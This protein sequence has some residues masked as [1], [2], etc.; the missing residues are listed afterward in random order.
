VKRLSALAAL[1]VC[2]LSGPLAADDIS[3]P[4]Y[5]GGPLSVEA[6]WEFLISPSNLPPPQ[7]WT[8]ILPDT[9]SSVGGSGGETLY[10]GFATH[11]DAVSA[12][13]W[14]WVIGD[15]DG[16]LTPVFTTGA[17]IAF[18]VQNWVDV[19][20]EKLL[21][22]QVTYSGAVSPTITN[23]LAWD[24]VANNPPIGVPAPSMLLGHVNVDPN[25]FYEDWSIMPNPDWEQIEIFVPF[26]TILDEVYIDTISVPGPGALALL[27]VA[28]LM[29]V[30]RRRR[31]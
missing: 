24:D 28:G 6:E 25:H 8:F 7:S 20:P 9:F 3:P 18:N 30:R 23:V 19:E 11:A 12:A 22:V 1:I 16:G 27:G 4:G 31:N 29:A 2:A 14:N 26:N 10:G 15:G 5:R 13:N 21:R 17:F